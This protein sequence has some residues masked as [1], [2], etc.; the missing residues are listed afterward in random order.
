MIRGLKACL[1]V[2]D[3]MLEESI[4]LS[5]KELSLT[6]YESTDLFII[7]GKFSSLIITEPLLLTLKRSF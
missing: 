3:Y 7:S 6:V 5:M 1:F 4:T 2:L